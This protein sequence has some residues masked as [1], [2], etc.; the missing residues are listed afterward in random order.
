MSGNETTDK[1]DLIKYSHLIFI[2]HTRIKS[3]INYIIDGVGFNSKFH[4]DNDGLFDG[5]L[6]N[7]IE[8]AAKFN[9]V[10]INFFSNN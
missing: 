1:L 6:N 4:F 7:D 3:I 2:D 9:K 8:T 10:S 5:Y